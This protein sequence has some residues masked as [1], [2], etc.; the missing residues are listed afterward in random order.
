MCKRETGECPPGKWLLA[1]ACVTWCPKFLLLFLPQIGFTSS[2]CLWQ[3]LCEWVGC[4]CWSWQGDFTES[5]QILGWDFGI[6]PVPVEFHPSLRDFPPGHFL[7]RGVCSWKSFI[8]SSIPV[9]FDEVW[10]IAGS[11]NAL[12]LM[13]PKSRLGSGRS[14]IPAGI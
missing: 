14:S 5:Q 4:Q 12:Y 1:S 8:S 10:S 7:H 6:S 3:G 9:G 2:F 11:K 13:C